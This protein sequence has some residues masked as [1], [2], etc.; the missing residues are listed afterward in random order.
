VAVAALLAIA[1]VA[2]PAA[3]P[4]AA[5]ASDL[6]FG[7]ERIEGTFQSDTTRDFDQLFVQGE[8]GSATS[9]LLVRLPYLKLNHTG[10]VTQTNDGPIII[11][12][13]GPGSP[14]FQTS[15]AEDGESGI[16]DI[17]L[18][19]ETYFV[20]AG[21]GNRPALSMVID[22]KWPT[23][24]EKKGLGTGEYDYGGGLDYLQPL[25]QHFQILG[26]ATYRF[27]GSPEGYEFQDRLKLSAGFA[28]LTAHS[29]WRLVGENITPVLDN[30]LLYN[31]AGAAVGLV[32]VEDYR[33]VRGELVWRNGAGGSMRLYAL[34]GLN[35]SSPDIGYGLVFASRAQ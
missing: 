1:A 26:A 27:M 30:V 15:Q 33:V 18:R 35:D 11:G 3:P 7:L 17:S 5:S 25:G 9:R 2:F 8:F 22:L 29:T 24:D 19:N 6:V 4:A 31:S 28:F 12:A 16:G 34:T 20:R 23:A 14:A 10:N 13:G 32:P 21:K